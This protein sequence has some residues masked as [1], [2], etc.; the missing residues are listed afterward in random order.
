MSKKKFPLLW[1]IFLII[2]L[3]ACNLPGVQ[4]QQ[5]PDLALTITAQAL[6]LEPEAMP[7]VQNTPIPTSTSTPEF[8]PTIT[9]TPTPSVPTATV[10]VNTNCRTG[11][12]TQYD[13][14]GALLIG[15]SAEVVGKNS[16]SNYWI[17]KTPGSIG[18]CWLWGQYA[19]VSGNTANLSEYPVPATPTPSLPAP[20]KNLTAIKVCIPLPLFQFNYTGNLVWEDKS[21]NENG[22]RIFMNG[23]LVGATGPDV[24]TFP[25]PPISLPLGTPLTMAVEAFNSTGKSALKEV[26]FTCP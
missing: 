22:F 20:V 9:L 15:Q 16:A 12:G 4:S 13:Q 11:P 26:T 24:I 14:I 10:S 18:N 7:L 1:P 3:T 25:I 19:T 6:L 5:G 2:T 21:D 17:I 8:T 23:G